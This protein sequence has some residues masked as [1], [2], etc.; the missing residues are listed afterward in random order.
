MNE[1]AEGKEQCCD[2][3]SIAQMEP[4]YDCHGRHKG[5]VAFIHLLLYLSMAQNIFPTTTGH[6]YCLSNP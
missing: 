6:E 5:E 4:I 3:Y 2:R 1:E